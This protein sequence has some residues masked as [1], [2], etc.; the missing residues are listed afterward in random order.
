[1]RKRHF[2]PFL[3]LVPLAGG[4]SASVALAGADEHSSPTNTNCTHDGHD[5]TGKNDS[6]CNTGT[7]PTTTT[8]TTT[9]TPGPTSTSGGQVVTTLQSDGLPAAGPPVLGG[10]VAVAPVSGVVLVRLPGASTFLAL[11]RQAQLPT[12]A[13]IDT[14]HGAVA[15]RSARNARGSVQ[16]ANFNGATF[17]V[18]QRRNARPVTDLT[19]HGG[20]LDSCRRASTR[21]SFR[22]LA[23]AARAGRRLW[24]SGHGRFRTRGRYGSATVRGTVWLTEDRCDGTRVRV[25]RGRVAVRDHVRH[26]TVLVAAGHS[27]LA[28]AHP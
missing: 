7:T 13:T 4:V 9:T 26:R 2:L 8:T 17:T 15:L 28:R 25:A 16:S 12:G 22:A 6:N 3:L 24:G 14:T 5:N 19:L 10:A 21:R 27:Y 23:S 11:G 1:M 20:S 18:T